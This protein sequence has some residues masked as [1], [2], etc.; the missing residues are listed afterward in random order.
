MAWYT[1][2]PLYF[3]D[4]GNLS[5][6]VTHAQADAMVAAAAGVWNI[7]TA[8]VVLAKGGELAEHVT[9]NGTYAGTDLVF[10]A[11]VEAA[12]YL[13]VQIPVIYDSDG[14]VIDTLLGSGASGV[15]E[16]RQNGVVESVDSFGSSGTI[17]HAVIVLNGLC[18]GSDPDSLTQMQYQL[19]RVFGRVLGLAWSQLNDNVFTGVP[20]PTAA[21]MALWPLMHPMDVLCGA[22]TY[23]CMQGAFT[24]RPDD[25]NALVSLYPVASGGGGK[26]ASGLNTVAV[27]GTVTFPTR[28]G[29]E[30]ANVVAYR[31]IV[32]QDSGWE[33]DPVY[34]SSAGFSFQQNGG[35]PTVGAEP[36]SENAGA[37][38]AADEG[39]WSI[40]YIMAGPGGAYLYFRTESINPLYAG[41]Y[42]AG[43]YQRPVVALSGANQQS[44]AIL[45]VPGTPGTMAI[46]ESGGS[47]NWCQY[48]DSWETN[49]VAANSTG[50]WNA[51][52][53]S[54]GYPSSW[55]KVAVNANTSWTIEVT[56]LNEAGV[57]TV[58]KMQPVIGV[59][60]AADATGTLPTVASQ[61][62]AMNSMMVGMTQLRMPSATSA[63]SYRIAIADKFGGLRP[64]FN[65]TARVL[66]ASGVSPVVLGAGGGQIAISG[67]GFQT[68]N[69]VL[70]N[71]V[72]A[73][74]S[75]RTSTQIVATAPTMAAAGVS[76]G[77]VV[78][79]EVLD[80]GTGGITDI[81]GALTY[82]QGTKN[83]VVLVSAP[84]AL[85]TGAV[86]ATPFAVRVYA[87]DGVTP[88]KSASVSFKVVGSGGGAAVATG[89]GTGVGCV[90][91]TDAT[92][93]AQ[94]PLLGVAAGS[95]TVSGTEVSGGAAVS[96][97]IAATNPLQVVAIGAAT[98]YLAAGAAGSWS[99]SLTA[100]QDGLAASGVSVAWSTGGS[101]FTLT[102]ATGVTGA[103]GT[104]AVV[105]R[106]GAIAGGSTNVVSGCAWTSVCGN[107]TVFGVAASQWVI[108]VLSGGGQSVAM[109]VAP[110]VV[111]LLV[112]DGAGHPLP[113]AAVTV[114]QTAYAWEGACSGRGACAVAPVLLTGRS[115]VVS[116]AGGMVSVTA[117]EK[118]GVAQVVK[119]AAATGTRGF[120]G[121]WVAVGP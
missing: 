12:N 87:A 93:L 79:V 65:Y 70:V 51:A 108:A 95:V 19:T 46:V 119:I 28:Q 116:D 75:S 61:A 58:G 64:D 24:L 83:L 43:A 30:L 35:N 77:S 49:A 88:T 4:P 40:P 69:R 98:Q 42:A 26:T 44:G 29:M 89:C 48:P 112:T 41:E 20:Q 117:I 103:N 8:S 54:A 100:T 15:G 96:A 121:T 17:Q 110:A 23:Q 45:V 118:V 47:A 68:G 34:S 67:M 60:N 72:A 104:A 86:A 115:A 82:S 55:R 73:A 2:S 57:G 114:Y 80:A 84:S 38:L 10:P 71:G 33:L 81:A 36:V 90:L 101:G 7:P 62:M 105:A 92:G 3:T 13:N 52:I 76:G 56:A 1:N 94:T 66:Y 11:D 63:G 21:Q 22:Y 14:S 97:T 25:I 91:R 106:V 5:S 107:W 9:G 31:L 6:T 59:W 113:G 53:C 50:W 99:L 111:K 16:C 102:P 27:S 39:V 120:A 18:V 74:V 78:D 32:G 109:G 85:E 37:N